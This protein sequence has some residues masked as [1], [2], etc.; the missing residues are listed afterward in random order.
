[1]QGIDKRAWLPAL[2]AI[3]AM[4]P[5]AASGHSDLMRPTG[6]NW[7]RLSSTKVVEETPQGVTM[8]LALAHHGTVGRMTA[9][10]PDGSSLGTSPQFKLKKGRF[11]ALRKNAFRFTGRMA[12]DM[13]QFHGSGSANCDGSMGISEPTIGGA[14]MTSCPQNG[15]LDPLPNNTPADFAG[16][17]RGAPLGTRVRIEYTDP[18]ASDGTPI[19]VHLRTDAAGRFT[20]THAF[21]PHDDSVYGAEAIPRYPDDELASGDGCD[22]SIQ[23]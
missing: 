10:C 9:K 17:V 4:A 2:A 14:S 22:F 15:P 11:V 13:A 19:V 7:Q 12:E 16:V 21:P 5:A 23:G 18:G 3:T 8:S 6:S 1:M 20:D